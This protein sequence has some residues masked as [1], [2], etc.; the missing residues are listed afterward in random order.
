MMLLR[1]GLVLHIM[2]IAL[3]VGGAVAAFVL[4]GQLWKLILSDKERARLFVRSASGLN[5]VQMAGGALI[6]TGGVLMMTALHGVV[7]SA[8]WF[9]IKLV[10]LG[11]IVLNAVVTLRP[12]GK[13]LRLL[14]TTT[15]PSSDNERAA[16]Y[17][18]SEE[19]AVSWV[20]RRMRLFYLL[21]F[22]FFLLILILSVFQPA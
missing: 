22:L 7:M 4:Q 5:R 13:K 14:L 20:R 6:I 18:A 16:R 11:L 1:S 8:F 2:G 3:M 12:A 15:V 9:R 19:M 17:A 21:Q 10:L